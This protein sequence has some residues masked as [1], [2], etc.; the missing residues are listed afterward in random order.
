MTQ[1]TRRAFG[2]S[3]GGHSVDEFILMNAAGMKVCVI[4]LGGIITALHVPVGTSTRNVVLGLDSVQ[5]YEQDPFY[6]GAVVGRYANRIARGTFTLDGKTY[7][8]ATNNGVNHLHGGV[9]GFNNVVWDASVEQGEHG[10]LLCL[11][12]VSEDGEEGYPGELS[13]AVRYELSAANELIISAQATTTKPCP[14]NLTFHSYFNLSGEHTIQAHELALMADAVLLTDET[15]I[16]TGERMP[17]SGTAFDFTKSVRVG[18]RLQDSMLQPTRGYDHNWILQKEEG[19]SFARAACL[20]VADLMLEV[21]T[22][23]PG[24]QVYTGNFLSGLFH[25]HQALCLEPQ[26]YPDAPNHADFPST[27]LQPGHQYRTRTVYRFV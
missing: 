7:T 18:D 16:P 2:T 14:V 13:V 11:R 19:R 25:P 1:I 21:Y 22:D 15:Q 20:K 5:A 17:V 10:A 8:L 24:M 9:R 27:I 23:Q 6:L 3:A 26:H 12:Y 4:N